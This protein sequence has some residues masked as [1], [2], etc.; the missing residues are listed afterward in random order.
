[1]CLISA[2]INGACKYVVMAQ[3]SLNKPFVPQIAP[4]L[5]AL[6]S[7][8]LFFPSSLNFLSS[9]YCHQHIPHF[10]PF[11]LHP[12]VSLYSL[13][14]T[15]PSWLSLALFLAFPFSRGYFW[16]IQSVSFFLYLSL[17]SPPT[18]TEGRLEVNM[19]E[20]SLEEVERSFLEG[21][22]SIA[23]GGYWKPNDCLPRWKVSVDV[24]LLRG[25]LAEKHCGIQRRGSRGTQWRCFHAWRKGVSEWVLA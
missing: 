10:I 22:P 6:T 13:L 12:S 19:S 2:L 24:I 4:L 20:V 23:P 5:K 16:L 8:I 9:F 3:N 11:N 7:V 21:E 14:F 25:V 17:S 1:M 15:C 18:H